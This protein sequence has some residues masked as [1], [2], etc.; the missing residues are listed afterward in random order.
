M[1][2]ILDQVNSIVLVMMENRSFDHLLGHLTIDDPTLDVEGLRA[3]FDQ[4]NNIYQGTPF[5]VY[6]RDNDAELAAD[7]PHEFNY[8]QT[9][10]AYNPIN[11]N[12]AMTGFVTAYA[13]S[14]NAPPNPQCEP[15]GY[16]PAPYVP[17][18]QFLAT[19]FCLCDNWFSPIPTS[20]QPNR[21]MAFSGDTPIH[22]TKTQLID[23]G[24]SNIFKWLT[25]HGVSWRVYNEG[26][27]FFTLYPKLIPDVLGPNFRS[28]DKLYND[29][30][31]EPAATAPQVTIIE[32]VYED[33]P[34]LGKQPDDN[35]AP[36]VV[37]WGEDFLRRTYQAVTANPEKWQGTLMI[38]YYDEHGGFYDHVQPRPIAYTTTGGDAFSFNNTGPR[39]PAILISPF[40]TPGQ[41]C[42]LL[43]DHTSVLQ[44]LAEKF[45]APGES[46]SPTVAARKAAGVQS[47]HAALSTGAF[48]L[49]SRRGVAWDATKHAAAGTHGEGVCQRG[50]EFAGYRSENGDGLS[51]ACAMEERSG[52]KQ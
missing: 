12:F 6:S 24:D 15:M 46:W 29:I 52:A 4:Y 13:Q 17:M 32:P 9:Q 23:I 11:G 20:T 35:H 22:E 51:R 39:I 49:D 25:D 37:G 48:D 21:T 42:H 34:H 27:S 47:I 28:Y 26:F 44:L 45:G 10:L 50:S 41:P 1:A 8:V 18:T 19:K 7:V 33:A 30:M 3:P 5:P 16:F 36:L 43:F 38:L 2:G 31:N 14:T 40:V